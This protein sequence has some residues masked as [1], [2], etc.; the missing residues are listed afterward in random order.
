MREPPGNE[1]IKKHIE[2]QGLHPMWSDNLNRIVYGIAILYQ[3]ARY[4][5]DTKWTPQDIYWEYTRLWRL[6]HHKINFTFT[7]KQFKRV[8]MKE[9]SS[10][11]QSHI[12]VVK[13]PSRYIRP[14]QKDM[15]HEPSVAN[16]A[17]LL[18]RRHQ[19]LTKKHQTKLK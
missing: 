17:S 14:Q 7:P 1:E 8:V 13:Q 2:E 11:K 18:Y 9:P 16:T 10:Q 6:G 3:R 12:S 5:G 4:P 15:T 19:L